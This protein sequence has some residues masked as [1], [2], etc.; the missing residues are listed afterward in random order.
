[1]HVKKSTIFLNFSMSSRTDVYKLFNLFLSDEW[2]D[3]HDE[4]DQFIKVREKYFGFAN[5][6]LANCDSKNKVDLNC[7]KKLIW[8]DAK[9]GTTSAEQLFSCVSLTSRFDLIKVCSW[10]DNNN[11]SFK[12]I[13]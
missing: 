10:Y 13:L 1:M 5:K 12:N 11:V 6:Y 8:L 9:L 2:N 4:R 3:L 7:F